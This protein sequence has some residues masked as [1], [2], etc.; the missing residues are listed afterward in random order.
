MIRKIIVALLRFVLRIFFRRIEVNG[1]ERVPDDGPVMFVLNHPNALVDP[2]FILALAPRKVSFLAKSTFFKMPV[3]GFLMKAMDVIPVY[4]K[5]DA[6]EDTSKNQETFK[7]S[8]EILKSGGAIAM[9]PEG[10]SHDAPH[11]LPLKT[12]A[13]RIALGAASAGAKDIHLK[14]MPCGL[15]Y[16]AKDKF[17]SSALLYFGE[18]VDVERVELNEKG[19]PPREASNALTEKIEK[20]LRDVVLNAEHD[21]AMQTIARAERVFS[22]D[23]EKDNS[24]EVLGLTKEFELK[25]RFIEG[26]AY[27]R[28]HSP[29]R[30]NALLSRIA[31]YE[32][33]LE[34]IGLDPEE[35]SPP[36]SLSSVAFYTFSR[37]LLFAL[38]FPFTVIGIVINYPAYILIRYVAL[39]FANN[40]N[41]I[42]STIKII[43]SALF[44]PLTWIQLSVVCYLLWSWKLALAALVIAPLS[45]YI[46]VRFA[47][48]FDRFMAGAL[49]VGFFITRKGFFKRLLAERRMIR[50]EIQKLGKEA[51]QTERS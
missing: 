39:R 7:I 4:R 15:Y 36:E 17:R 41:D 10:V 32:S 29:E 27:H 13:A 3:V 12:G 49:S 47:E 26:Y 22:S 30:L 20:E 45:G 28:E 37:T 38:L 5:Q 31:R 8:R 23:F 43:A 14:I 25:Q 11:L 40:Y 16:T 35:L 46:A 21:E 2:V 51:M 24:D 19:E 9:C 18:P 48:E 33:E 6:G 44:F 1:I 50:E 42:L 34:Q